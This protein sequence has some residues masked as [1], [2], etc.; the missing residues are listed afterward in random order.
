[1]HF[2]DQGHAHSEYLN[3]LAESGW[4]GMF[5]WIAIIFF[6]FKTGF[7]LVYKAID[8]KVK[9]F[10]AAILLGLVTY[11]IH[12]IVNGYS[13]QDKIAVLLWGSFAIIT[14]LD[15]YH[16]KGEDNLYNEEE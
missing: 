14:A 11:L 16:F 12:G 2:G 1:T 4:I 5:S 15:M 7:N 9:V 13:D 6:V 8:T 3:P 10:A